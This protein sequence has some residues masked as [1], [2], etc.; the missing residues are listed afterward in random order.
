MS[1]TSQRILH[2]AIPSI[3]SN[4][5]VPLLGLIDVT[6]VGHLGSASYIGAIA[7]G[8]MLFN[9]IYWIFGFLRMDKR[10]DGTSLRSTRSEGGNPHPAAFY[11]YQPDAG[12]SSSYPAISDTSD[13]F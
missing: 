11:W 8:G 5:T 9:M 4:I 6:I 10:P 7:V 1:P 3:I 13:S 12:T 2:I